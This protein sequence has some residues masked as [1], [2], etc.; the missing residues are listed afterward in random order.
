M[1]IE[2]LLPLGE[3][4]VVS[5]EASIEEVSVGEEFEAL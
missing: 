1:P 5:D 4:R 3:E 2:S